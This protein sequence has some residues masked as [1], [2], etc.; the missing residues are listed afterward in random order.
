LQET[1][2]KRRKF[3]RQSALLALEK[4]IKYWDEGDQTLG[5]L[6]LTRSLEMV[7]DADL[8][9]VIRYNLVYLP[10]FIHPLTA[11]LPHDKWVYRIAFS[12]DGTRVV[13]SGW[14]D[15]ARLWDAATGRSLGL[16][17]KH[18]DK[19]NDVIFSPNGDQIL[20]CGEDGTAWLWDGNAGQSLNKNF[21]I[22]APV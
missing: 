11:I 7:E 9:R 20:T 17:M 21:A 4:G 16:P 15:Y 19:V 5:A 22:G 8:E 12:S 10:Y 3:T 18:K 2:K 6:W 1:D 14:D 13:T